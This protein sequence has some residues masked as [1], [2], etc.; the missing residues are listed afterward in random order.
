MEKVHKNILV[1]DLNDSWLSNPQI[2]TQIK[3]E[4]LRTIEEL[5]GEDAFYFLELIKLTA[6]DDANVI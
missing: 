2:V 3:S 1:N 6:R 5:S 4:L